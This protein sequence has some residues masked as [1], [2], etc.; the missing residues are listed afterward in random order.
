MT[1]YER[2]AVG[3]VREY[4][5]H[6]FTAEE[7]KRFAGAFD[8]QPFHMDEAGGQASIFGGLC[9]S[10]WHT[11]SVMMRLL[12]DSFAREAEL[13]VARGEP[14]PQFGPSP[15]FDDLKWL[16]PVYP[17]DE[18]TFSARV[19]GKRLSKSRPGWGIV[20]TEV[21]GVN[22]NGKRVFV[23]TTQVF[24]ARVTAGADE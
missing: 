9:A 23:V 22:Q 21:T 12:V 16:K 17:G 1:A 8:P 10:G 5:R 14:A 20:S 24:A 3:D 19:V 13:A 15:G 2:I 6:L 11:A 18:V 7:I 4:G